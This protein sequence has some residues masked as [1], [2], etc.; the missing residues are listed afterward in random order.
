MGENSRLIQET[1]ETLEEDDHP[2]LLVL[3]TLRRLSIV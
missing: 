2:G 3:Q 1:I